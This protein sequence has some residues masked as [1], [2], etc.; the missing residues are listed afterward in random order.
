[1]DARPKPNYLLD[2]VLSL[3]LFI[4]WAIVPTWQ[5]SQYENGYDPPPSCTIPSE[6][7]LENIFSRE[8]TPS[9]VISSIKSGLRG[10]SY[11]VH[12][13]QTPATQRAKFYC[14]H[15]NYSLVYL[16]IPK[17]GS[18]TLKSYM[19]HQIKGV[20]NK[21]WGRPVRGDNAEDERNRF[22][23]YLKMA[24]VREPTGHFL[25]GYGEAGVYNQLQADLKTRYQNII[26]PKSVTY[27]GTNF[28]PRREAVDNGIAINYLVLNFDQRVNFFLQY[29]EDS[30]TGAYA[31]RHTT[32]QTNWIFAWTD[33]PVDKN[34][35]WQGPLQS[36]GTTDGRVICLADYVGQLE[37][38]NTSWAG[39]NQAY[40]AKLGAR[41]SSRGLPSPNDKKNVQGADAAGLGSTLWKPSYSPGQPPRSYCEEGGGYAACRERLD[42]FMAQRRR[43]CAGDRNCNKQAGR[44]PKDFSKELMS[45]D[46]SYIMKHHLR[47]AALD[48]VAFKICAYVLADYLA[49]GYPLPPACAAQDGGRRVLREYFKYRDLRDRVTGGAAP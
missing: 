16:I 26:D 31:N 41:V 30:L 15:P 3:V 2:F 11:I 17:S 19:A 14:Y 36:P 25:S 6:C 35:G 8:S 48:A 5:Q 9:F 1:M 23:S 18:T 12:T 44:V 49:L 20:C 34:N 46:A 22:N 45:A 42:E 32:P 38:F 21:V 40:K 24:F 13:H 43:R 7:T 37:T 33:V 10:S 29:V 28:D 47:G 4:S 27:G 39:L